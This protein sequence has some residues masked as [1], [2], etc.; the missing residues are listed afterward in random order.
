MRIGRLAIHPARWQPRFATGWNSHIPEPDDDVCPE[1]DGLG[2]ISD[3]D[4]AMV[5]PTCRGARRYFDEVDGPPYREP[6]E[7]TP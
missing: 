6:R 2:V 5:C 4:D 3:S 7:E 1:C